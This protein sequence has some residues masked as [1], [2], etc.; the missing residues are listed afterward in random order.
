MS[1]S[2][3]PSPAKEQQLNEAIA[4][5]LEQAE[6]GREPDRAAFLAA[7]PT[8]AS[9]LASFFA[10]RDRFARAAGPLAALPPAPNGPTLAPSPI[11]ANATLGRVRCFG[12]YELL[13]E[14]ARGG[15]GVVFQA[16]QL[17]LN[18]VVALKMILAGQLA[19][20]ADVRRFRAEA[21]LAANLDHPNIVPIHEVGEHQ[22][23]HYFSMKLVEGG[24][25]AALVPELVRAPRRAIALLATAAR[26]V[27][28]AHQRGLLHRDLK[29]A[30]VLLD[31]QDQPHVTDF[32]LA[33]RV[34]G[35]SRAT[36]SGV[37]VGTPSY[38]APEQARGERSLS[39]AADVY[40]LGAILYECLTGRP[41][42]AADTPMDTLLQVLDREPAPPRAI[43]PHVDRDL[44]TICLKC[45]HKEP[46]RR[47]A[48]AEALADDLD[49]WLQGRP[50]VARPGSVWERA[51]KWGRRR[52]AAAA[53]VAVS[54]IA[55]CGLVF[56]GAALWVATRARAGLADDLAEQVQQTREAEQKTARALVQSQARLYLNL[57]TLADREWARHQPDRARA[58]LLQA[59]PDLRHVEWHLLN[60][61]TSGD[62]LTLRE[63][64]RRVTAVAYD[65][66]G[67]TLV[68]ATEDKDLKRWDAATGQLRDTLKGLGN[69]CL[70]FAPDG[71]A[72]AVEGDTG[73]LVHTLGEIGV[74]RQDKE[75]RAADRVFKGH[76][77]PICSV[78]FS[79]DGKR[80][81]SA[82]MPEP[83]LPI[84]RAGGRLDF[85]DDDPRSPD[86]AVLLWD[87]AT[88]KEL[89]RLPGSCSCVAFRPGGKQFAAAREADGEETGVVALYDVSSGKEVRRLGPGD[90][91]AFS[92]DGQRLAATYGA[93]DYCEARVYDVETGKPLL[94]YRGHPWGVL[95]VAFSPDGRRVATAGP[96]S[97]RIWDAAT[98]ID[99][100][101]HIW[102]VDPFAAYLGGVHRCA[103]VAF[104]PDGKHV[105]ASS[106]DRLAKV[107]DATRGPA[108]PVLALDPADDGDGFKAGRPVA[109]SPDGR[110]VASL[111]ARG[112]QL[113]DSS[114]LVRRTL[115]HRA[116]VSRLEFAG[117]AVLVSSGNGSLTLWDVASGRVLRTVK[118][119]ELVGMAEEG[120]RVVAVQVP[121]DE[122]ADGTVTG[123]EVRAW[124]SASG[125]EVLHW[126]VRAPITDAVL[127]ADGRRLAVR[128]W[129]EERT[130]VEILD[131]ASARRLLSLVV[132]DDEP[133]RGLGRV[134]VSGATEKTSSLSPLPASLALSPGGERLAVYGEDR[135]RTWEVRSGRII[136]DVPAGGRHLAFSPDGRRLVSC[137]LFTVDEPDELSYEPRVKLYDGL[138]GDEVRSFTAP[139]RVISSVAFTPDGRRLALAT[140]RQVDTLVDPDDG[141]RI[142][143]WDCGTGQTVLDLPGPMA[144]VTGLSFRPDGRQLAVPSPTGV[145]L[146]D[147]RP[148]D[149]A[150]RR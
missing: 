12:D 63:H 56:L 108:S 136:F 83:P 122:R 29:P 73:V 120:K 129:D 116:G 88:G 74:P 106:G 67:R 35:D 99:V 101:S 58:A 61:L 134:V 91:F 130:T 66:S 121:P 27:H 16:R 54:A 2:P 7:H 64:W 42:F 128:C 8:L 26:A 41:P 65:P 57:V 141:P 34:E 139:A 30:N 115:G 71:K 36:R 85:P 15:M 10:D 70:A 123:R 125:R 94:T 49:C 87:V 32:G 45:L 17:S 75:L 68:T 14:I 132:A 80:L 43:N 117:T 112:I 143:L 149:V 89:C 4:T 19:S 84:L 40:G 23:Q 25:L 147:A 81:V 92:P 46:A 13:A 131:T 39:V 144:L 105:V 98:G 100:V 6:A 44:E 124:E 140:H 126:S 104:S 109:F 142:Q 76:R 3:T 90:T 28:H 5:Y 59:P 51:W 38:M 53:L 113:Y 93:A 95:A 79:H 20:E 62:L 133:E 55:V 114:G 24:S 78:A 119:Y 107:L 33:K 86:G 82:S 145:S 47:Y 50:I 135:V 111:S 52:P 146:W 96:G 148:T 9:E 110:L 72:L 150:A 138:T 137:E 77:A 97:V 37:I 118:G 69:R 1:T 31:E 102:P 11:A 60:N 103:R 21:E 22:G 18:R 48:S 127:S